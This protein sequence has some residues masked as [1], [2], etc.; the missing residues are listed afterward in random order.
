VV[1]GD[2]VP[3]DLAERLRASQALILN[4]ASE[5]LEQSRLPHYTTS[6]ADV[7]R[8]RL[9]ALLSS[10][11]DCLGGRSLTPICQHA[12]TLAK[13]RFE[14]G[15]GIGEVQTAFNVLEE[16]IWRLVVPDI[17]REDL[18]ESVGLIGTIFGAGRDALA[19]K[20]VSLATNRHVPTLDL[21]ALFQGTNS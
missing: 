3:I 18:I 17:P 16:A 15:Y 13:K 9:D 21:S 14:A 10:A 4:E 19:N 12:Q 2:G 7:N 11:I 1:R 8:R 5:A 20:W 6:G